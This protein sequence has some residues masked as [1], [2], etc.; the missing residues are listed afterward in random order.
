MNEFNSFGG[1]NPNPYM[2]GYRNYMTPPANSFQNCN[3]QPSPAPTSVPMG[4]PTSNIPWIQVPNIE[5]ARNLMI[6]PNQTA[7]MMNQNAPEFYVKNADAMGVA[8][9][10]FY[11][12]EE[13]NPEQEMANK[14]SQE[15]TNNFVTIDQ[16]NSFV[17]SVS[18]ELE[19]IKKTSSAP[20][21]V[22]EKKEVSK[23]GK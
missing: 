3:N 16:F 7:Y 13:F 10:K 9:M 19:T 11:R 22:E 12:F 14:I 23:G 20:I 1:Y 21:K 17:S 15:Q 5:A 18:S 2:N 4:Q 8:T 6:G